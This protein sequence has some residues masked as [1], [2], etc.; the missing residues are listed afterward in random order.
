MLRL[1]AVL[2]SA[3][4]GNKTAI[5]NMWC[6]R[7][8][9]VLVPAVTSSS[10]K[11]FPSLVTNQAV[12][13][14]SE[15]WSYGI[16]HSFISICPALPMNIHFCMAAAEDEP[17]L[18]LSKLWEEWQSHPNETIRVQAGLHFYSCFCRNLKLDWSLLWLQEAPGA[19]SKFSL[20]EAR[21]FGIV[22]WKCVSENITFNCLTLPNFFFCLSVVP[23]IKLFLLANWI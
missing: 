10:K 12:G 19:V 11:N 14:L 6:N 20:K 17:E 9:N 1:N 7:L 21:A 22:S 8:S 4:L 13:D 16:Y 2:T 5:T 18:L 23:S 3:R 15:L